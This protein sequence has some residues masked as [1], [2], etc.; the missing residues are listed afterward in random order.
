MDDHRLEVETPE[1]VRFSYE[2]AGFGSRFLAALVD[3]LLLLFTFM[4]LWGLATALLA[5]F[6]AL[7]QRELAALFVLASAS[8]FLYLG[9]FVAFEMLANGQT[10]GKRQAGLRVIRDDGTPVGLTESLLRNLLRLVDV[11]PGYYGL[12][13][14]SILLSRRGKRLGDFVA[15]T[16]VVKERPTTAP[17]QAVPCVRSEEGAAWLAP[18]VSHLPRPHAEAI[19]RFMERRDELAPPVRQELAARLAKAV[20]AHWHP[21]PPSLPTE[22]EALLELVYS[23]LVAQR[24]RL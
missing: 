1:H 14:L 17:A 24:R 12:G 20:R 7:A 23:A 21:M 9:Y 19:E 18:F 13:I 4:M 5:L 8:T 3:H 6:P 10:P 15:G 11:L 2:L 22:P 16:V